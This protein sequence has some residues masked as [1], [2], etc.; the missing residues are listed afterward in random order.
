VQF[1]FPNEDGKPYKAS[2]GEMV[3]HPELKRKIPAGWEVGTLRDL[4]EFN[5]GKGLKNDIRTGMGYPVIGSNGVIGYHSD[6][7]VDGPGLVVGRKGTIGAVTFLYEN[8]YPIDTTYYIKSKKDIKLYFLYFLLKTLG[9]EKMNSD[10]AVPGL[11]RE[12]ALNIFICLP[13]L[14]LIKDFESFVISSFYKKKVIQKENQ[15]L[16]QLRDWLLP[17]LM[18]GQITVE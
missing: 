14:K 7:L 8:F 9:L 5:Y 10:S 17:L 12:V 4:A 18:N 3:Y 2:G 15:Q 1:D 13:P 6:F 16:T 11:S